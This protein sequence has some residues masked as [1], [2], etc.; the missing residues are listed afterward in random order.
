MPL[1]A[2]VRSERFLQVDVP[3]MVARHFRPGGIVLRGHLRRS[4]C[5]ETSGDEPPRGLKGFL[6]D[7]KR[8]QEVR[9]I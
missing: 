6:T 1:N 4:S 2:T 5:P 7:L 8:G 3:S 9:F